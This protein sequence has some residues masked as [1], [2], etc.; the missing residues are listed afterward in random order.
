MAELLPLLGAVV[1]YGAVAV[2]LVLVIVGIL[3]VGKFVDA[4]KQRILD[5]RDAE[6]KRLFEER[7]RREAAI[8]AER[9]RREGILI[10]ERDEWR[11]RSFAL[12]AR[13]DRLVGAFERLSKSPAPD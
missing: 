3:R 6:R 5:E 8:V 1:Q 7:D 2:V 13:N 9:D 4:E 11:N 10:A 12:D